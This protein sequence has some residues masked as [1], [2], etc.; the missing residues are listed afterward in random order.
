MDRKKRRWLIGCGCGCGALGVTALGVL[1]LLIWSL[2]AARMKTGPVVEVVTYHPGTS[3]SSIEKTITN[4]IERWVNQAKGSTRIT[5]RSLDGVSIVRVHFRNDIDEAVALTQVCQLAMSAQSALPPETLPPV[6]LPYDRQ[7]RQPVGLLVLSGPQVDDPALRKLADEH[8]RARM[9]LIANAVVPDVIG[10]KD[11]SARTP[12]VRF[13]LDGRQAVAVPIHHQLGANPKDLRKQVASAL[14]SLQGDLRPEVQLRWLPLGAEHRS[15]RTADDGLLTLYLRTPS[16]N[17]LEETEKRVASVERV[18]E[19]AIPPNEREAIISEVGMTPDLSARYTANAGSQ[20]ATTRVQLSGE[21]TLSAAAYAARL[22]RSL[23]EQPQFADLGFRFASADMPE[24]IDVQIE[25][26]E[27]QEMFRLARDVC[28]RLAAIQGTTDVEIAQRMDAPQLLLGVD[29]QRAELIGLS[30]ADILR[31]ALVALKLPPSLESNSQV[32]SGTGELSLEVPYAPKRMRLD[33]FLDTPVAA[34][35]AQQPYRLH[36]LMRV[37]RTTTA[38]EIDHVNLVRVFN[39]G[40]NIEGRSRTQVVAD[41]NR[42]LQ[43]L[44]FPAGIEMKLVE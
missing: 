25:G 33:D 21:R 11:E 14:L 9:N 4:R 18:L 10:G 6:V 5:S 29:R 36:D 40:A 41:V 30:G 44:Q 7:T 37:S 24:P 39:V 42:M 43:E 26:G 38:V 20:D 3:A 13:R 15:F 35:K 8:V 27:P 23:G 19:T 22:R 31:Q 1:A 12:T 28:N 17:D 34:P 16:G 2:V 32:R